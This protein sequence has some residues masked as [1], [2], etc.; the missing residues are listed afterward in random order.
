MVITQS[1]NVTVWFIVIIFR[2][3]TI[4]DAQLICLT[5]FIIRSA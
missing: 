5:E 3:E 4:I 1:D 2:L